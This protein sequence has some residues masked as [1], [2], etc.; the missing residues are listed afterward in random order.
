MEESIIKGPSAF[1]EDD[2]SVPQPQPH[3]SP[4]IAGRSFSKPSP[5]PP[6]NPP[7]PPAE[8]QPAAKA[9]PT[10]NS[11]LNSLHSNEEEEEEMPSF[12]NERDNTSSMMS[13][14]DDGGELQPFTETM[15][16]HTTLPVSIPL[17]RNMSAF[18]GFN[19]SLTLR[20]GDNATTIPLT[21]T[22]P[23]N[24]IDETTQTPM[25]RVAPT[26]IPE[27]IRNM[28]SQNAFA[29][30][31]ISI[32]QGDNNVTIPL[33]VGIP[34]QSNLSFS[35]SGVPQSTNIFQMTFYPHDVM[36]STKLNE[37]SFLNESASSGN[38]NSTMLSSD[39]LSQGQARPVGIEQQKEEHLRN[40]ER[41]HAENEKNKKKFNLNTM[42]QTNKKRQHHEVSNLQDPKARVSKKAG[43]TFKPSVRAQYLDPKAY[44]KPVSRMS[45]GSIKIMKR[46]RGDVSNLADNKPGMPKII[47]TDYK[48]GPPK[49]LDD[50]RARKQ[51]SFNKN[52]N[53][54]AI[55]EL[56]EFTDEKLNES[57][58]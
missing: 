39:I 57:R 29:E 51:E 23:M 16:D 41:L 7:V 24:E 45:K 15:R 4:P 47:A 13:A 25:L 43:V 44:A 49:W 2:I 32:Q 20:Q 30:A 5:S 52:R 31:D 6:A 8:P 18:G 56:N 54:T 26:R 10:P 21:V 19:A 53:I 40:L 3:L 58:T 27:N 14:T 48:P 22:M 36:Q 12:M 50:K 11:T 38:D 9:S 33:T 42:T 28:L 34:D 46:K 35:A 1:I 55:D 37:S 17:P